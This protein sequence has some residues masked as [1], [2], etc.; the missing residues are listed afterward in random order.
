M[1]K[2]HLKK[3]KSVINNPFFKLLFA[4]A[5]YTAWV[6][7]MGYY[8]LLF[9]LI[10][11]AD[12]YLTRF[13]NWRF[14]RKRLPKGMQ[15]KISTEL[16]DSVLIALFVAVFLRV[17]LIEA[18]SIPTSSMERTLMVGDY[19]MVSKLSYGPRLPMTP[20]TIPFSHNTMPYS[21]NKSSFISSV[22]LP[23]KR[24]PGINKIKHSDVIVFNYPEGDTVI[25]K[26]P[27]KSYY[28]LTRQYGT[29]HIKD[30]YELLYRP[31]DKRDNYVKRVIGIPGD[32]VRILSG[33]AYVNKVPERKP[34][35]LQYNYSVKIPSYLTDSS[36]FKTL[37]ISPYDISVNEYNSVYEFPLTN[38]KYHTILD[39]GYFKAIIRNEN[40]DPIESSTQIFPFNRGFTW[41]EDNYGPIYVPFKGMTIF[42]TAQNLPLYR[43]I[44]TAYEGNDIYVRNNL[45]YINGY[46]E[47][48]YT[49]KM[50][51]YFV[52]GDNR[53]NSNDSRYWGFVPEDHIIGKAKMIWLSL[54][55]T[56]SFPD[57]IRW[58]RMLKRI[59]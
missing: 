16:F 40:I 37:D 6:L 58:N 17:Y 45:I 31:V 23:Y 18:Y 55:R 24:L 28:T 33:L 22:Q 8:L 43:R 53:H 2:K 14:W 29:R 3:T 11:I 9:G 46:V 41:T 26:L 21:K 27:E 34:A 36:I 50:N 12:L 32:T 59:Y 38:K 10:I 48:T 35:G 15:N 19:I 7:W 42:L 1:V 20:L 25:K 30:K 44:I 54:D 57:N 39:S 56:Q 51:Y 13:I 5:I 47:Q 4:S 49:F 52:M